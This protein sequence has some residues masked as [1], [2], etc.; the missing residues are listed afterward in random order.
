VS[1]ADLREV[2]TR[3]LS[4]RPDLPDSRA[5]VVVSRDLEFGMARMFEAFLAEGPVDMQIFRDPADGGC[6][7]ARGGGDD[8][9]GHP[10]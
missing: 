10:V 3:H 9:D 7:P 5:A 1:T 2:A 8:G 6:G 4:N